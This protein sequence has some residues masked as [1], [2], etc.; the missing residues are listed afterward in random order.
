MDEVGWVWFVKTCKKRPFMLLLGSSGLGNS[1]A[2]GQPLAPSWNLTLATCTWFHVG[3]CR[4]ILGW[5]KAPVLC[6]S[7]LSKGGLPT[8]GSA[9]TQNTTPFKKDMRFWES[10]LVCREVT[11]VVRPQ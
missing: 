1:G 6:L 3:V 5:D 10:M 4:Q 9:P 8:L 7:D 2:E 11:R